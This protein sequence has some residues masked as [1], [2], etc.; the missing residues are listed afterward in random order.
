MASSLIVL[1]FAFLVALAFIL[2]KIKKPTKKVNFPPGPTPWPIVGNLFQLGYRP[3]ITLDK[4]AKQYGDIM[5]VKFGMKNVVMAASPK[6]AEE[7]LKIQDPIFASRPPLSAGKYTGYDFKNMT[8]APYGA[9]WKLSRKVYLMELFSP[10]RLSSFE[11]V[12][13]EER[14]NFFK[15]LYAKIGQPVVIKKHIRHYT[16]SS[17]SRVVL[18]DKYFT[19]F[20]GNESSGLLSLDELIAQIDEWMILNGELVI[21]DW[22]PFLQPL[23]LQGLIKRM[24]NQHE[25]FDN[26]LTVVIADHKVKMDKAGDAF[27]PKDMVDLL[28]MLTRD[29]ADPD[30]KLDLEGVKSLLHDLIPGGTDTSATT[31]EWAIHELLLHPEA[32]KKLREEMDKVTGGERWIQEDDHPNMPYMEA[33]IKETLRLHP[34]SPMLAPHVAIEDAKVAGYDIPKGTTILINTWSI[35]RNDAYWENPSEFKPE[36]FLEAGKDISM[37]GQDFSLLPFGAGRRRCPGYSLGLRLVRTTVGNVFH[38]FNWKFPEGFT[39]DDICM[40]ERYGLT[41]CPEVSTS[42]I[43]EPRFPAHFYQRSK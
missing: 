25:K 35:G 5:R 32:L 16:L 7:F 26:F 8:W 30:M 34:L 41:T 13:L 36:R 9:H 40:S 20:K 28:L 38:G 1:A 14:I 11:P 21:G 37:M 31:M 42:V 6:M 2:K 23:D 29:E 27:D 18:G 39:K 4:L 17:I 43:P 10:K 19:D 15:G 22:I 12:R 24:K 3:H 33:V